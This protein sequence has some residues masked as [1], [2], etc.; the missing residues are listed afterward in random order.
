MDSENL[1]ESAVGKVLIRLLAAVMESRFRY[2]FFGP[3][4]I[5][6]GSGILPGQE[7][8]EVGC[9]TGYFT[10]PAGRLLGQ[11]GRL[12]AID[13]IPDS[14]EFV[15][16]SVRAAGL[17]NTCVVKADGSKTGL[18]EASFDLCLLFGLIPAPMLPLPKLLPE[19]H[20]LLKPRG[21]LAV[22]PHVP[23]W[24]PG[25][26]IRSGLFTFIGRENGVHNFERVAK[27]DEGFFHA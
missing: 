15:S 22:W 1:R 17:Q 20:R 18:P 14:I 2:R 19:I 9:G 7:V 25:S 8:L 13:V 10:V 11:Y 3:V 6:Q 4:K 16:R 27:A 12:V 24:L 5:L 23:G 26:I 21:R